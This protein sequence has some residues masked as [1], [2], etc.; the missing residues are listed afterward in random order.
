MKLEPLSMAD[1]KPKKMWSAF[2]LSYRTLC[3]VP[4]GDLQV[5]MEEIRRDEHGWLRAA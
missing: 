2:V 5:R 3:S 1:R 4:S